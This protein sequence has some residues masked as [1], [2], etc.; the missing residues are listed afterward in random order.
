M[1]SYRATNDLNFPHVIHNHGIMFVL[2]FTEFNL[3]FTDKDFL[4]ILKN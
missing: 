3:Y 4:G 1:A 2:V